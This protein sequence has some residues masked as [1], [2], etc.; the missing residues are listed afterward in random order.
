MEPNKNE[1]G[2]TL[3]DTFDDGKPKYRDNDTWTPEELDQH[4]IL[5]SKKQYKWESDKDYWECLTNIFSKFY[6]IDKKHI[7]R[8]LIY[9]RVKKTLKSIC[10]QK[11]YDGNPYDIVLEHIEDEL[12]L[13]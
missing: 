3:F 1:N 2:L 4:I 9:H 6:I 11:N 5:F 12:L 8:S 13:H 7:D 10:S